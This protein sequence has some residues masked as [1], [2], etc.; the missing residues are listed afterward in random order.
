MCE[1]QQ[2]HRI[3][4]KLIDYCINPSD[5]KSLDELDSSSLECRRILP[6]LTRLWT[7]DT[8]SGCSSSPAENNEHKRFRLAI[9]D[10]LRTFEDTNRIVSYLSVDFN[11]IY[12]DVIK[13]LSARKKSQTLSVYSYI[14]FESASATAKLLM[15][16]NMLLNGNIRVGWSPSYSQLWSL[17]IYL[18]YFNVSSPKKRL[19]KIW[20]VNIM[21]STTVCLILRCTF[22]IYPIYFA[23]FMQVTRD[24]SRKI[25]FDIKFDLLKNLN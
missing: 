11:Q 3:S 23:L 5:L 19:M 25:T 4:K 6:F 1:A 17:F 2:Q 16:S 13:H 14:E 9:Y 15:I 24:R 7:R 10:K 18:L 22:R 21:A 8:F 20:F 12:E